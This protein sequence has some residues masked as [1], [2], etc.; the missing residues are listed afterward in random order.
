[1][2]R[3]ARIQRTADT[4][5]AH[6]LLD[7]TTGAPLYLGL[8]ERRDDAATYVTT[9]R[10][11]LALPDAPKEERED[12][13]LELTNDDVRRARQRAADLAQAALDL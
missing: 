6:R 11:S 12:E 1:V 10:W 13:P 3:A 8:F 2:T 7:A 4:Y 9:R 5:S